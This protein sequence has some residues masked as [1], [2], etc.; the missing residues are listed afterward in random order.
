VWSA[1]SLS[2]API[3]AAFVFALPFAL[4]AKR[5]YI[6][7]GAIAGWTAARELRGGEYLVLSDNV[8][9]SPEMISVVGRRVLNVV[10]PDTA[11]IFAASMLSA[12]GSG[13][14]D[15][16]TR[17]NPVASLRKVSNLEHYESGG[18]GGEIGGER[19]LFGT[20]SFIARMGIRLPNELIVKRA[21]YLVVNLELAAI[22]AIN[23][24]ASTSTSSGLKMLARRGIAPLMVTR[25]FNIPPLALKD[26]FGV[27]PDTLEYPLIEERLAISSAERG[28][29][30]KPSAFTAKPGLLPLTEC[31]SGAL[32]LRK[33]ASL[34]RIIHLGCLLIGY[35][36]MLFLTLNGSADAA[37]AIL[38]S[39]VLLF[40]LV[41]WLP[42]WAA[43]SLA[44]R[45]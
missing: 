14:C 10:S 39:N 7:G 8:L 9:F 35:A 19:V 45:Y 36:A 28:A 2:A 16:F 27:D 26:Q 33:I 6:M 42:V 40:Y 11:N 30:E 25:D 12:A 32:Q 1:L 5:L 34:N 17:D 41:W 31:V 29:H 37:V 43:S 21:V 23:Y 3:T 4:V 18:I 22:Y 20:S 44:H 13:L 15:A 38:P 24:I